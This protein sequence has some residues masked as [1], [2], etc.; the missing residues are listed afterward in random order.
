MKKKIY[1]VILAANWTFVIL[2][3]SNKCEIA[4]Y[5]NIEMQ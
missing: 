4:S 2:E 5:K 3:V 1:T